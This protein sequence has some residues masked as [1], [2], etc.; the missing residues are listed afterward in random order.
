MILGRPIGAVPTIRIAK[1]I[2]PSDMTSSIILNPD[3][4]QMSV[5]LTQLRLYRDVYS[6][7]AVGGTQTELKLD[8]HRPSGAGAYPL[9]VFVTGGGFV[10]AMKSAN[11]DQ[12]S[13]IAEQGYVVASIEYRTAVAGATY[14]DSVADVKSAIRNPLPAGACRGLRHRSAKGRRLGPLGGRYLAAMTGTTNGLRQFERGENLTQPSYVHAVVDQFAPSDLSKIADD[15]DIQTQDATY[16]PGNPLAKFVLGPDTTSSVLSDSAAVMA[17]NPI[18]YITKST[19]PFLELHGAD[20]H[21]VSP[22]QTLLL[23]DALQANAVASTRY[24]LIGADHGDLPILRDPGAASPWSTAKVMGI[25][26]S[27][28]D[29]HLT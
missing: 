3:G 22:S 2:A 14:R 23:H 7:P 15:Y 5:G 28:L 25:I 11:V 18:T 24:V 12:R 21:L 6:R 10:I 16:T 8:I 17:A 4:A 26:K 19:P 9:V 29:S 27:F 13:F 20:D 1:T